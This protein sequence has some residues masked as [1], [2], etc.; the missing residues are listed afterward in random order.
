MEPKRLLRVRKSQSLDSIVSRLNPYAARY[1]CISVIRGQSSSVGIAT[2]YRMDARGSISDRGNRFFSTPQHPDRL[3]GPPSLLF[4][5]YRRFIP[6]GWSW[7]P[8]SIECRGQEWW[9]YNS[10]LQH[11][12]MAWHLVKHRDSFTFYFSVIYIYCIYIYIWLP[13]SLILLAGFNLP[14]LTTSWGSR[15]EFLPGDRLS[16][17]KF[18]V[19]LFSLSWQVY[20]CG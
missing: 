2:S 6:Q 16:W 9:S 7:P 8:T 14:H 11:F 12:L 17:L 13:Q 5:G 20:S 15:F 19:I 10:T 18:A 3:W 1:L 4:S